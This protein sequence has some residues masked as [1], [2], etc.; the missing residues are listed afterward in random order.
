[1]RTPLE[2]LIRFILFLFLS[3]VCL[4]A[5]DEPYEW[6]L[7]FDKDEWSEIDAKVRSVLGRSE[8][9]V[10]FLFF[11]DPHLL[12]SNNKFSD[13]EKSRLVDSFAE[14]KVLYDKLPVSFCL[15][16]GDWLNNGDTQD[17]AKEKLLLADD[18]MKEMFPSYFKIMGNHDTNYQG[19]V[20]DDDISRGDLSREW[21]DNEYYSETGS[22][23]FSFILLYF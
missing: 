4:I 14:M 8:E 21:V 20:S 9:N 3:V 19:I 2:Q 11:T 7:S 23:F 5:C 15:S 17:M 12:G 6:Q 13:S 10:A 18:E 16:G 1:M 22:A